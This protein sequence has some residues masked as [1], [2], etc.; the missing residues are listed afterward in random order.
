MLR[1]THKIQQALEQGKAAGIEEGKAEIYRAWYADWKR[2]QQE[3]EE[4][5]V[6]FNDPPPPSPDDVSDES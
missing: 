5:G 1:Y 6:P 2:R 4:K 3:A